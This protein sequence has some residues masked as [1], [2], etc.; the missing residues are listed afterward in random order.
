MYHA[1][2]SRPDLDG[3]QPARA[4]DGCSKD[5]IPI[6]VGAAGGKRVRLFRFDDFVRL[7]ELPARNK[8]RGRRQIFRSALR[9]ALFDP[10]LN[11]GNLFVGETEFVGKFRRLRLRQPRRH[12]PRRC[13]RSDLPGVC[14]RVAVSE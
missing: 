11:E 13:H 9:S 3:L 5:E 10:P 7:A 8:F 4:V 2:V 6:H 1:L 14:F 12:E